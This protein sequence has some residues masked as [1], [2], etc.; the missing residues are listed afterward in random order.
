MKFDEL[1]EGLVL[2]SAH[3]KFNAYVVW[4]TEKGESNIRYKMVNFE[5]ASKEAEVG[6]YTVGKDEWDNYM[7]KALVPT[8]TL[9][10]EK[11]RDVV[12]RVL[13]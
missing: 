7:D 5:E 4:I 3:F 13:D 8:Y 9:S 1:G 11:R 10:E 6:V 12:M 2:V